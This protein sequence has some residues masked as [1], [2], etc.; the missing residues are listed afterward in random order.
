PP[1]LPDAGALQAARREAEQARR[2]LAVGTSG[3]ASQR[4]RREFLEAQLSN[5]EQMAE[6]ATRIPAAEAEAR[7]ASDAAAAAEQAALAVA[8]LASELEGLE[9]L[10][11]VPGP[12][13]LRLG[14]VLT[15]EPGF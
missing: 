5:L 6:A 8:R 4:T 1:S 13:L 10:R 14:D 15:A 11:P 2:A 9:A 12:G 7:T 3:L